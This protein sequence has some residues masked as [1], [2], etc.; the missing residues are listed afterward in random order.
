M[1]GR[2]LNRQNIAWFVDLINR[3][4]MVLDPPYQR[5][6]VWTKSY[7][8]FFIDTIMRN[9]PAPSIF[10]N[11]I[12]D[13]SG[14]ATYYVVDGKQ[15]LESIMDFING[16]IA[17]PDDFGNTELNGKYFKDLSNENK[18]KFWGYEISAENLQDAQEEIINDT[19]DR[20]NRN[21]SKLTAQELRHAKYSGR[22]ISMIDEIAEEPYW[23]DICISRPAT[24]RRMKDVEFISDLFL[25]TMHGVSKTDK[26]F[27]DNYYADYDEEIPDEK[28]AR[29]NFDKIKD[30]VLK[31]KLD[32]CSN[33][34][35]NYSDFYC[36]WAALL[37]VKDK[38]INFE[39]TRKNILNF[40]QKVDNKS[41]EK[42]VG[43]YLKAISAQPNEKI[44][45][46]AR[47]DIL[48][49]LIKTR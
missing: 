16:R 48:R 3:K 47:K 46:L 11:T 38:N 37:E 23:E 45:R 42:E 39:A 7:K 32:I 21:V 9:Y 19:F 5:R 13:P 24:I 1:V 44:N 28:K 10:L 15:R 14:I 30:L 4:L 17:L 22:F 20:L 25:L 18:N 33:R 12:V 26:D 27:L 29:K 8:R 49:E 31:L 36:L 6:S 2:T 40:V 34:L 35:N 41:A 43:N